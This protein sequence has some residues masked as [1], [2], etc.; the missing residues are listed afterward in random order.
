[1]RHKNGLTLLNRLIIMVAINGIILAISLAILV[2]VISKRCGSQEGLESL[3][4]T[5]TE[6]PA[7][8]AKKPPCR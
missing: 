6:Q 3:P 1:M 7:K 4:D 2:P 8:P 5:T